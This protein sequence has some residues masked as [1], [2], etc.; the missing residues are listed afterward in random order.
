MAENLKLFV[1][2][3][4]KRI[5]RA[6]AADEDLFW[7]SGLIGE[8][9]TEG[10]ERAD[11]VT[12]YR[13]YKDAR[14]G[15]WITANEIRRYENLPPAEGGDEIQVTPVG[16]APNPGNETAPDSGASSDEEREATNGHREGYV[17]S[18]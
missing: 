18:R 9:L 8:F 11:V 5:E 2:P 15:S 17:L 10:L 12:R 4:L 6:F 7:S 14:Q 3:R 16:G 13:A 1:M